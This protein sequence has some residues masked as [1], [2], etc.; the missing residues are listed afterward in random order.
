MDQPQRSSASLFD[1]YLRLRPSFAPNADRFLDV[2]A[3]E[4]ECPTHITIRPPAN[5]HRKRAIEKFQF[6]RV[7]QEDAAQL[8]LFRSTGLPELIEGVLGKEKGAGRDGLLATLGVTGSGKSHTILGSKSQRGLT[9]MSL[10]VLF[11]TLGAQVADAADDEE[12]LQSICTSDVSEAQMMSASTFLE[13]TYGDGMASTRMS[14]ATSR[15][16]TPMM[17][18]SSPLSSTNGGMSR[19]FVSDDH[20]MPVG[21][22]QTELR[23]K[24]GMYPSLQHEMRH[25]KVK[26]VKEQDSPSKSPY[27][28]FTLFSR[29]ITEVSRKDTSF[30]S[31]AGANSRKHLP[32][33]STLPQYP[34]VEDVQVECDATSEYAIVISMYEVYNDR[35]FDLLASNASAKSAIQKRRGLL[36]K[37]TEHSPDRKVVAGLRK[38]VCSSLDEALLVL[39]TGLI[40]RRVAGTGSNAVS[41]RSH[42]FFCVEV[43]KRPG[44][45]SSCSWK[46]STLTVVDLAG[47]E[48]AR[49]AKTTGSTLAEAGKINESL[50]YLGQCMQLQ[51]DNADLS[52]PLSIV[53]FRQ[54]KL[55]ELLF[56]NSFPSVA[57]TA[58]SNHRQPQKSIMIVTADPH[59]DF[60]A[61]SQILR[62]SALA[63]EVTV[64]RIPSV[65]SSIMAPS[66][67]WK[68]SGRTTPSQLQEDLDAALAEI[69]RLRAELEVVQVRADEEGFRRREAE[70]NWGVATE[71][72]GE[73]EAEVREEM[74]GEF[75]E[76]LGEE[77]KRWREAREEEEVRGQGILD[78]KMEIL[79]RGL[80]VQVY[81][82]EVGR[83]E[84]LEEENRRLKAKLDL[85]E[86]EKG[87]RTPSR[88]VRVLK[89]RKW[90]GSGIGFE[91]SP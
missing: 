22:H 59:G 57:A 21:I 84:E 26:S 10:D 36:F 75:E 87:M 30:I 44:R 13:L 90:E 80:E 47:S 14:R 32:R 58:R 5:D 54:C 1:V 38:V 29:T 64:P 41:S 45:S 17:V 66:G 19:M 50:M 27:F 4:N 70:M 63:R 15:G 73:I 53:P 3:P 89:Q 52:K 8:D 33:V 18:G 34:N 76:R 86:R 77:M 11:Q 24:K 49:V 91:G 79:Q 74:W 62:Y 85:V 39:E 65:T 83:V 82:D 51:S 71:R 37:S 2:E 60:N 88:K 40:E 16:A 68:P 9:Q 23:A 69:G 28:P 31:I 46:S 56:S 55:T 7:F 6:T 67:Q 12:I 81:E 48:R 25:L 43:K 61:T 20:D 72:C 35:I 78:R 42:G